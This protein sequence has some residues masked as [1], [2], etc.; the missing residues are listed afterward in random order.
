[1]MEIYLISAVVCLALVFDFL[2]GFNDSNNMV[3]T[4]ISSRAISVQKALIL[5]SLSNFLGPFLFGTAVATT[6][7]REIVNPSFID[8]NVIIASLIGAIAW[9]L[10][11]WSRAVPTSSSHALIGSIIGAVAI[12]AGFDKINLSG[13][14]KVFLILLISPILGFTLGYISYKIIT[15]ITTRAMPKINNVFN[16][17]QILSSICLGLS[18][19]TNDAQKTMGI[20][21]MALVTLKFLPDFHVPL[22]VIFVCAAA[23][24][25]G[26]LSGGL[27]IVK[28]IGMK[29]FK[30]RPIHGFTSQI[31][32]SLVIIG[33]SL[34]GG[35]VSTTHVVSSSII[36]V[37][38]GENISR[39]RWGIVKDI[40]LAWFITLPVSAVISSSVCFIL[41]KI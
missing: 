15:K 37:G 3:A 13:I 24:A 6:I 32:S 30:I 12:S 31:S 5:A 18:H 35:P 39:I 27:S 2:N 26:I 10:I 38:S 16:V 33:S 21:T 36:G 29:I 28:T 9:D 17:L 34:I 19:G 4:I 8:V 22:W 1:M 40:V 14:L 7:G 20:V 23:M 11:A 41:N 25:L